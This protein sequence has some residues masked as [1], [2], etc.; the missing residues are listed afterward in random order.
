MPTKQLPSKLAPSRQC[1]DWSDDQ[2]LDLTG[3]WIALKRNN[4]RVAASL[5]SPI[6]ASLPP[7]T[8]V[9]VI[10]PT[11]LVGDI[12]RA[13]VELAA[14]SRKGTIAD[15][16]F[17]TLRALRPEGPVFYRPA[18]GDDRIFLRDVVPVGLNNMGTKRLVWKWQ[19]ESGGNLPDEQPL[20]SSLDS[21]TPGTPPPPPTSVWRWSLTEPENEV[22]GIEQ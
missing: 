18:R 5:A 19:F 2:A 4:F 15:T 12:V 13:F 21:S 6:E 17:I 20:D 10:G 16:G 3:M 1:E 7:G 14:P 22:P 8:M 9:R 11:M